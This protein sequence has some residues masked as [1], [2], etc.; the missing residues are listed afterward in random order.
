MTAAPQTA[1]Y[2]LGTAPQNLRHVA[3]VPGSD[4]PLL[5]LDLPA[6]LRGA[7]RED[8]A[9]RQL[10]DQIGAAGDRV[11]MRPFAPKGGG[12]AWQRVLVAD[13]RL[14]QGWREQAGEGC[15][16]ILPDYLLLP[17][18]PDV[19]TV[20]AD[21]EAVVVRMGLEDGFAADPP[22]ARVMLDRALDDTTPKAVL[23]LGESADLA[24]VFAAREIAC[25]HNADEVQA[26]GF[27]RPELLAHDELLAD[28]RADPR[29]ARDRL[30]AALLPWLWP[31]GLGLVAAGLWATSQIIATRAVEAELARQQEATL[32]IVREHF[33]PSGPVLD[34]RLQVS[35]ALTERQEQ[36][37]ASQAGV[38]VLTLFGQVLQIVELAGAQALEFSF[39]SNKLTAVLGLGDFASAEGVVAAIKDLPAMVEVVDLRVNDQGGGVRLEMQIGAG[40]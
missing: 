33:V 34:V 12:E 25:F 20:Q 14:L 21:N 27:A 19:W 8:V 30:R 35:R 3:A 4:V 37:R 7:A 32:Q 18:A 1:I 24:A 13:D 16:A 5:W 38:S 29:A 26:A 15:Q 36:S 23:L 39:D 10:R 31:L 17:A 28:L 11:E 9:R 22:M 40:Q 2:A 6:G